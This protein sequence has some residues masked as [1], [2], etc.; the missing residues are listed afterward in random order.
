M[1]HP[2]PSP[3]HCPRVTFGQGYV[4]ESLMELFWENVHRYPVVLPQTL[5]ASP[6]E[7]AHLRLHNGTIWR[8][9][10]P[11]IGLDPVPHLRIEQRV[12][13][14]GPTLPDM[15]ANA[16]F[17]F[18][19]VQALGSQ[20]VPPE[21]ELSFAQCRA[22][23]YTAA[24]WGLEAPITWLKGWQGSLRQLLLEELIPQAEAGL[25]QLDL[26]PSD[27]Q[28]YLGILRARVESGQNGATWQRRYVARHG[29]DMQQLT[30]AYW[31][32]QRQ[33]QPVHTWDLN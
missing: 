19:L 33:G 6:W 4:Q 9:N 2:P 8:W 3:T 18:G 22:N 7:L 27:I 26:A 1:G 29:K 5:A 24:R 13:A 10:R 31:E 15:I 32:R 28:E 23:F 12:A 25:V 17:Y 21:Q 11:L 30:C 20:P 14:A 16:A